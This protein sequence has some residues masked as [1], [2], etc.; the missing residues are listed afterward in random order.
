MAGKDGVVSRS[1]RRVEV[2]GAIAQAGVRCQDLG[3]S[4]FCLAEFLKLT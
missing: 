1:A 3:E 4:Q 2:G